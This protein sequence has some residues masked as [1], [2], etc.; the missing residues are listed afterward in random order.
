M[1]N[2]ETRDTAAAPE[3]PVGWY[4]TMKPAWA[5]KHFGFPADP[6]TGDEWTASD[7]SV[8]VY[9]LTG[10]QW[11][12]M[13]TYP[14]GPEP[15]PADEIATMLARK[16][17]QA[18]EFERHE[19]VRPY[20]LMPVAGRLMHDTDLMDALAGFMVWQPPARVIKTAEEL[21]ALR[22]D[23]AIRIG[24]SVYQHGGTW[25]M[26]PGSIH[27]LTTAQII[28][29]ADGTEMVVLWEPEAVQR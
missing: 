23:A 24:E 28:D 5:T 21:D 2:N 25:W 26:T 22:E 11:W 7:G 20:Q 8:W 3:H 13:S 16:L 14:P 6:A 1:G 29:E 18:W 4:R 15:T 17:A 27:L 9:R 19:T 12:E 10:T